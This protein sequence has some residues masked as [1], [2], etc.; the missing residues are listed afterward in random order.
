MIGPT[1]HRVLTARNAGTD[2]SA[3]LT[4]DDPLTW[5]DLLTILIAFISAVLNYHYRRCSI[6]SPHHERYEYRSSNSLS[7]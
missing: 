3:R 5:S 6:V 7:E 4:R 1:R 2:K